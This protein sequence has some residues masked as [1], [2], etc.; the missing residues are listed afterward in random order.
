M[1]SSSATNT[2]CPQ[3]AAPGEKDLVAAVLG[4]S[5]AVAAVAQRSLAD[6]GDDVTLAQ[7]RVLIELTARGPQRLADLAATLAVDRSTATRVC[8]RLARKKLVQRRRAHRD[9]RAVHVSLTTAGG[10][11]VAEVSRRRRAE[12]ATIVE[13]IPKADRRS[14]LS[15]LRA[16]VDSAGKVPEPDWSFGWDL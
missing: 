8:D 11:L 13:R 3:S 5:R 1:R 16:F 15:T 12:V 10:A 2:T 4:A 14:A 6:V 9:R 7:Y